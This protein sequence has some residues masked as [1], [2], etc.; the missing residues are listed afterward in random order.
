MAVFNPANGDAQPVFALDLANGPQQGAI[1]AAALVQMAGPKLDFFNVVV[2][3]GSQQNIDLRNQLGNVTSGVFTPGVVVQLNQ[4]IQETA[5]IAMY[6]VEGASASGI[7]SYAVYPSGAY[8]AAT[9]QAQLRA[10]GNIQI[11][12]SDGTVTGVN[13]EGTDVVNVGFKLAAS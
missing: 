5:T 9:L 4:S 7:I 1:T 8:T 11:T 12:A 6:Q 13:V 10:L 3:N 2:Q